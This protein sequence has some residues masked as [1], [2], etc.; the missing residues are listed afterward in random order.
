MP[1]CNHGKEEMFCPMCDPV[2]NALKHTPSPELVPTAEAVLSAGWPDGLPPPTPD[3][4]LLA[5]GIQRKA[6][7]ELRAER[8]RYKQAAGVGS[9]RA[10]RL[11][12]GPFVE[13]IRKARAVAVRA[14][15]RHII[16]LGHEVRV[17]N[18][19]ALV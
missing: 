15:A 5:I 12:A 16:K 2:R 3:N 7:V 17:V 11:A 18:G 8:D 13:S 14:V 4:L 1:I 9:E 10:V 6:F 19:R